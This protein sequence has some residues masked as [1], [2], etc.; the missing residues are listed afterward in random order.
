MLNPR[1]HD[2]IDEL[3]ARFAQRDPFRHVVIDDF[4]VADYCAELLAAFPP[5]ESGNARN[6][7]GELGGKS[8]VE[9]IRGLGPSYEA[10]DD[11]VQ[12][13]DF[14]DLIGR[15]TG[16]PHLLYD[17][18]Y[19]G[20]GTHE[21]RQGQDLD[22]HVDFN[23]HPVEHWHR[24]LNL[25]VYLNRVWDDAWG[26]SLQLHSDP[27]SPDDRVTTITPLYNRAVIFET[28]E[29]SWHGFRRIDL[30]VECKTQSRKS[31]AV[32]FYTRERPKPE[33]VPPH[34]SIYVPEELPRSV[35][36]G[37]V[38]D[39]H[40][41]ADLTARFTRLRTQLRYIYQREQQF[42][43][44][45]AG[46]EHV[47]AETRAGL[48]LPLQ[49]YAT[50]RDA[51]QGMWPDEWVGDDFAGRFVLQKKITVIEMD[52]WVSGQLDGDQTLDIEMCGR[53]WQQQFAREEVT[54][55]RLFAP[56]PAGAEVSM[57]IRAAKHFVP[58]QAGQSGDD[59]VLAWQ[60]L[61][62]TLTH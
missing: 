59:R 9:K 23:R 17:P 22:A 49:G 33:T 16:I 31:F 13:R 27:R 14:L 6:E 34:A 38:L 61:G 55:I 45:I 18:W 8:T 62:I 42:N 39:A 11:L 43:A 57:R 44:Q 58:A 41:V 36:T 20:G 21:N 30:P 26:G 51:P 35:T 5:F 19:F 25:I 15:I 37:K 29:R 24:R 12:S 50:Q 54:K 40:D 7:A 60:L 1:L 28:T 53:R 46:L 52:V 32:Y 4:F 2:R 3:A 56:A 48:R 10:L 47:L